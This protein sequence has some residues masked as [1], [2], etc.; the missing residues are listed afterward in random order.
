V[1]STAAS[2]LAALILLQL[3]GC[4]ETMGDFGRP[5]PSV[6]HDSILPAIG[7][8]IADQN[9]GELVSDF[10][11]T[12]REQAVRDRA[13]YLVQPPHLHD[14]FGDTLVEFQRTRI[15][16]ELDSK[17]N[18]KAYYELLRRDNFIS[19][20]TRWQRLI[21]DMNTDAQLI[22]PF[23]QVMRSVNADDAQRVR[24]IDHRADLTPAELH[25]AYARIDENARLAD[26]VWR[27]MRFRLKSYRL[28]IDRMLV[29]TPTDRQWEVNLA[30][31]RLQTAIALAEQNTA[32][33]HLSGDQVAVVKRSRYTSPN[34]INQPV[35]QK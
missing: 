32:E 14:W 13:W 34:E 8:T 4:G 29:E 33:L 30:Y 10:N 15:L 6:L 17:F 3:A 16:P 25:N 20:E 2:P 28:C 31:D 23:W 22:G 11:H 19:S 5:E 12:D 26:W 35:P 9:R 24:S 7:G 1:S 18:T 27:S 21:N